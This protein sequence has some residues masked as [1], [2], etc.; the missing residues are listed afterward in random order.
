MLDS[1]LFDNLA[2][3]LSNLIPENL[4]TL[5]D[6]F[7]KN[8]KI[9]LQGMFAKLDLVTRDEFEVQARLLEKA[10]ERIIA[11]EEKIKLFEEQQR[12]EKPKT[13]K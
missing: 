11:L 7:E 2:K 9:T 4:K 12:I 3:Q 10:R 13:K 8:I 1:K 6:D 5:R